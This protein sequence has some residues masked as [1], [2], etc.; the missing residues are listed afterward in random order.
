M[1][2]KKPGLGERS[3]RFLRDF[4]LAVGAVA[5]SGAVLFSG[6]FAAAA[7][8]YA[9]LQGLQAGGYELARRAVKNRNEKKG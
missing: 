3:L 5:L 2:E 8:A 9:G 1:T 7:G 4:N 6:P